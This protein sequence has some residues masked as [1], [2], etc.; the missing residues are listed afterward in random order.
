MRP[1]GI[2]SG[3]ALLAALLLVLAGLAT[4]PAARAQD[5]LPACSNLVDDDGDGLTDLLDP[6]CTD[7]LDPDE[8][9]LPPPPPPPPAC[10]NGID[11][12]GDGLIDEDALDLVDVRSLNDAESSDM[13]PYSS[14]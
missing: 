7:P 13:S 14:W 11:D 3:T 1:P 9:D 10:A 5:V 12:D 6:G 4:A 8:T 2:T